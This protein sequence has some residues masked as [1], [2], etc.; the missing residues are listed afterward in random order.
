MAEKPRDRGRRE[1]PSRRDRERE[2]SPARGP[3]RT[4]SSYRD[5]RRDQDRENTK[6]PEKAQKIPEVPDKAPIPETGARLDLVTLLPKGT[7]GSRINIAVN[8]FA[9]QS[10]PVVKACCCNPG[11]TR[12]FSDLRNLD[13]SIRYRYEDTHQLATPW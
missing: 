3:A 6:P 4:Y 12:V 13:L 2:R 11:I 5:E 8:H 9:L 7:A 1:Q 10:L